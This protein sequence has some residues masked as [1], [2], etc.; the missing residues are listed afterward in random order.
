MIFLSDGGAT[1]LLFDEEEEEE[2]DDD[3]EDCLLGII[4]DLETGVIVGGFLLRLALASPNISENAPPP[5]S[6]EKST[7]FNATAES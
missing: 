1:K 4:E 6:V 3:E 2:D 7:P 5:F